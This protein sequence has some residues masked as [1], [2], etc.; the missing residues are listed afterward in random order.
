MAKRTRSANQ[1]ETVANGTTT[2]LHAAGTLGE[3]LAYVVPDASDSDW[4]PMWPP[5]AFAIRAPL[6]RRTGGYLDLING[7]DLRSSIPVLNSDLL[8][9]VQGIKASRK[10]PSKLSAS[11]ASINKLAGY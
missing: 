9:S 6:L 5:D 10:K 3:W 4:V 8:P 7:D 1:I 11:K 2:P